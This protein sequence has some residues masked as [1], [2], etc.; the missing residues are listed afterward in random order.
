VDETVAKL[1]AG[2]GRDAE[3]GQEAAVSTVQLVVERLLA[4]LAVVPAV[5]TLLRPSTGKELWIGD[6][7]AMSF[8]QHVGLGMFMRGPEGQVIFRIGTRLMYSIAQKDFPPRLSRLA[9]LMRLGRRVGLVGPSDGLVPFFVTGE[10]DVRCHLTE[11][12]GDYGFVSLYVQRC[13]AAAASLG[14]TRA[15][16]VVPPPPSATCP[17]V[18][19]FPIKG[20]IAARITAFEG[21]RTALQ[22]EVSRHPELTLLDATD[23]LVDADGALSSDL[24]DDGCHTNLAGVALVRGRVRGLDL[25]SRRPPGRV[26]A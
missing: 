10:I 23:Q 1:D 20:D 15:V 26:S 6:S 4:K 13:R 24:T 14:A 17:D 2:C 11:H 18:E 3:H 19:Q 25:Q 21:L 5:A 8:N 16:I 22:A 9:R 12:D 7:H